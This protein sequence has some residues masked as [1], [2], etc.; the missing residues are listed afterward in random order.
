ME[1]A[2]FP[3]STVHGRDIMPSSKSSDGGDFRAI[4]ALIAAK[5][6][7]LAELQRQIEEIMG[8]LEVLIDQLPADLKVPLPV[9]QFVP[10][11]PRP[12]DVG[13]AP[14]APPAPPTPPSPAAPDSSLL[15][16]DAIRARGADITLANGDDVLRMTLR[17]DA[18]F[19]TELK[20]TALLKILLMAPGMAPDG[21]L[22]WI[23]Y[24]RLTDLLRA[25]LEEP[26][27]RKNLHNLVYRLREDLELHGLDRGLIESHADLG[28]RMAIRPLKRFGG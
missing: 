26:V 7:R 20:T 15:S 18:A 5:V 6:L 23:G 17:F 24:D 2:E 8:D 19:H 16:A 21:L 13:H 4:V 12:H 22:A 14:P 3:A 1:A 28:V 9:D 11:P 27:T 25:A 10:R